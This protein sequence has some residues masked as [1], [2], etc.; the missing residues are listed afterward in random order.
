MQSDTFY[1]IKDANSSSFIV[2]NECTGIDGW[3][4]KLAKTIAFDD[5]TYEEVVF[6]SYKGKEIYYAGWQPGILIA[7]EDDA[8]KTIWSNAFPEWDH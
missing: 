6:I 1:V 5:L 2:P 3:F 7:F 8:G 4:T